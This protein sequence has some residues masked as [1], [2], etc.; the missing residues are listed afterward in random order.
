MFY[1]EEQNKKKALSPQKNALSY[2]D[3]C[4]SPGSVF[5]TCRQIVK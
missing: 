5:L 4:H 1:I 3:S 2:A